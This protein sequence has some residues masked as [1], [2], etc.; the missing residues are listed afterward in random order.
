MPCPTTLSHHPTV[1]MELTQ[2]IRALI[3]LGLD[4]DQCYETVM[5]TKN[6]P[7][8]EEFHLAYAAAAILANDDSHRPTVD[9][10][11]LIKAIHQHALDNYET[12][13]WDMIYECFGESEILEALA[14]E[15]NPTLER[16]IAILGDIAK[17]WD[18]RRKDVQAEAF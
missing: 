5:G 12:G 13:G 8:V 15:P 1:V 7:T 2:R 4:R 11:E 9:N 16:A 18:D 6:P 14:E 3:G 17:V 10:Q